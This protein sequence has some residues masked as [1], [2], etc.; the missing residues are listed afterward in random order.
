MG[1]FSARNQYFVVS[2]WLMIAFFQFGGAAGYISV[3]ELRKRWVYSA[4]R[5]FAVPAGL[6][7]RQRH[8]SSYIICVGECVASEAAFLAAALRSHSF[9]LLSRTAS[10]ILLTPGAGLAH[11]CL[12]NSMQ[13]AV[14]SA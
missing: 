6:A 13:T 4:L 10:Q 3:D 11:S 12:L 8:S 2:A 9:V 7:A 5:G 1:D 14:R